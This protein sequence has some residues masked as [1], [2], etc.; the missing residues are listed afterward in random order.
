M[1]LIAEQTWRKKRLVNLKTEQQKVPKI[2]QTGK[3]KN[4]QCVLCISE[5]LQA[6]ESYSL[7]ET[8][9]ERSWERE[10]KNI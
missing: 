5:Q 4:S 2:K 8:L 10:P 3:E 7:L 1:G 9:K 6:A